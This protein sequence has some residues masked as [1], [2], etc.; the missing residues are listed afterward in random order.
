M[1]SS[2]ETI[3][4]LTPAKSI[5]FLWVYFQIIELCDA[6]SDEDIH[7]ILENLPE[8]LFDTYT[9]IFKKIAKTGSKTT[10][11][12]TMMWM[13]CSRRLL[14]VEELQ[15]AVAFDSHDKSWNADKIPDADKMI[16]S[17][18]GLVVRDTENNNVRLAHHT[19]Q[20]YLVS[21]Q[22]NLP[23]TG[24]EGF[25]ESTAPTARGHFWPELYRFRCDPKSAEVMA[26]SL[27]IT[28]LCF[29]DFSTAV[30]RI[31]DNGKVDLTAAFKGRGPVSIPAALG[32]G[33]YFGSLPYMFLGSRN[34]FK[35]PDI[36]YSKYFN[37]SPRDRRPSPDFRK[38]FALLE[39][40]IE[41]WPWHTRWL[42][43]SSES[44]LT[45]QFWHLVEHG[46]IPFEFRP[47]GS[48][49]HFGPYGCK[50]CPV[51]E[52]DDL[53]PKDLPSMGLLHWAAE[54][55]QL[56][57]FDI[58]KP[59][60]QKYLKHERYHDETLLIACRHGQVAVI[61]ILLDHGTFD[62]SDGRAIIAACASG[63][64][65]TFYYLMQVQEAKSEL[66]RSPEYFNK[67]GP[68]ALHQAA[69]N[70]HK[71]VVQA[72]LKMK[73]E[74]FISDTATGLTPLQ[75]AAKNGHSEVVA[76]F[77][78]LPLSVPPGHSIDAPHEISGMKALHY[79][80]EK[81][82]NEIVTN[83]VLKHGWDC[84]V[85]DSLDE[86]PLIK[87]AKNGQAVVVKTL[88]EGGA[89]PFVK[90]GKNY[91]LALPEILLSLQLGD[92]EGEMA[93]RPTATHHAAA[94]GHKNVIVVL[95]YLD[96]TCGH[97]AITALHLGAAYGHPDA[98]QTLLSKG[99]NIETKDFGG[100]TALHHASCTGRSAVVRLLLNKGCR[101]ETR[102]DV[103]L[104]ALHMAAYAARNE[105]I[106]VLIA[107]GAAIDV[108]TSASRAELD[109]WLPLGSTPLHL[110][111]FY[112]DAD[113]V[114][115][116]VDCGAS[117]E[118]EDR[119]CWTALDHAIFS[120]KLANVVALIELGAKWLRYNALSL[121]F[122]W[123]KPKVAEILL[124]K[125]STS[126]LE[127]QQLAASVIDAMTEREI[128][129]H[130]VVHLDHRVKYWRRESMIEGEIDKHALGHMD[131]RVKDWRREW[132]V[133]RQK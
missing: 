101:L 118:E 9:R 90:G 1:Y 40:V 28:Y 133:R 113:T 80:A 105:V 110:A 41:H 123:Q 121:A 116:L 83:M 77:F 4:R 78:T 73:A 128:G 23:D 34:N 107:H 17:C 69:S 75:I 32:L 48:N 71:K 29:S 7:E 42:E 43:S 47:W 79:A 98:V 70:G 16:K 66:K 64:T 45:S 95:P 100:M 2:M 99:A 96:W 87:A 21:G 27:C 122:M 31:R 55:G 46:T 124:S 56:K 94:H 52:S 58:I 91:P 49:Q 109:T 103:G 8:G 62:L 130:A 33:K 44:R 11:L 126:T 86:T 3:S 112:A 65:L 97:Q 59:P 61:D 85:Q 84:E 117:L 111:A 127:E 106:K 53:E 19:V 5:R 14:R 10:A 104:T 88:L 89:D 76:A 115:T 67:V 22:G 30:N 38:K 93:P 24:S 60:L 6:A 81:G 15:E 51:P 72:L 132:E 20:Q 35:M 57:V 36:D 92:R 26:G 54:T 37:V 74:P 13:V 102:A 25:E 18:H 119:Y 39:Y 82:Y 68:R 63:K 120:E 50:G 131:H 114:R 125:I 129:K 12:K 108:K